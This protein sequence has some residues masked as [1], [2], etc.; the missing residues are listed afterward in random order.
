MYQLIHERLK[1]NQFTSRL[2]LKLV[3]SEQVNIMFSKEVSLPLGAK[4]LLHDVSII[5]IDNY[6]IRFP[7]GRM[8]AASSREESRAKNYSV[9]IKPLD[10]TKKC[11]QTRKH[12]SWVSLHKFSTELF[13]SFLTPVIDSR[14]NISICFS[15]TVFFQLCKSRKT[16]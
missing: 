1:V 13:G 14:Y 12:A 3:T 5:I 8:P 4:S 10:R 16:K 2:Q 11:T 9:L 7:K 6:Y 15:S